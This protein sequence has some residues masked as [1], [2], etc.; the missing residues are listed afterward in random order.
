MKKLMLLSLF[1][2]FSVSA[3]PEIRNVNVLQ[4]YPWEGHV[5]ILYTVEGD[6]D[7]MMMTNGCIAKLS[8]AAK[9]IETGDIYIRTFPMP[10]TISVAA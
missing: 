4:P 1:A 10:E 6:I 9:D 7:G 5:D 8:V 3:A 2:V